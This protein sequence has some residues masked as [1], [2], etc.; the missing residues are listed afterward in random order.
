MSQIHVTTLDLDDDIRAA[1]RLF[2]TAMVGLPPIPADQ[3]HLC[4]VGRTLGAHLDGQ[5]VGTVDSYTSWMAVPGGTRVPHAAVTHVGVLPTHTRRGVIST[6]MRAQ[7]ADIAARGEVVASLRASEGVIYER[8]GYGIASSYARLR[9]RKVSAAVRESVAAAGPVRFVDPVEAWKTFP[10]LYERLTPSRAGAI[11]RPH[12]WWAG[13]ERS[14][15]G[16]VYTMVHGEPGAADGFLRYHAAHSANWFAE[17]DKTVVVDDLVA[18]TPAAFVAFVRHLLSLDLVQT[19]VFAG[20]PVDTPLRQLLVNERALEV[21][22]VRDETWLR[23]IDVESALS[24]R[25][26][27]NAAPVVVEVRDAL[28]PHNSGRYLITPDKVVRTDDAADLSVEVAALS[29]TYLGAT[30]WADLV[31]AGRAVEVTA[32]AA[33]AADALFTTDRLP[34][35]GTHF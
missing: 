29:A 18:S 32:G 20:L 23:L 5:L 12:Y 22:R 6:L 4:E 26:Y 33:L 15:Q 13:Q 28:L 9:L 35:S 34:F 30:S 1:N 24:A 8:F 14:A 27:R 25:G 31:F 19:I 11:A 16:A 10:A 17:P 3:D 2:R 7:L 21:E